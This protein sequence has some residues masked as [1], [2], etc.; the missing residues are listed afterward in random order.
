MS[1]DRGEPASI[2]LGRATLGGG[3]QIVPRAELDA[4][5]PPFSPAAR[6][7]SSM[8]IQPSYS[9]TSTPRSKSSA[10]TAAAVASGFG[11]SRPAAAS[12]SRVSTVSAAS[13]LF[14]PMTPVGPRLIQPAQ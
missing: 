9:T 1:P 6:S 3:E 13:F 11:S 5:L 14:V 8:A 10:S 7:A 2:S 4:G 12:S